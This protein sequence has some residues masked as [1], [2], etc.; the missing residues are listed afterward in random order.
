C[1][2]AM[3]IAPNCNKS[4]CTL[5]VAAAGGGIWKTDKALNASNWQY[6][7][8]SFASNAIGSLLIDPR[9]FSRNTVYAGTGEPNASAD[10]E[11]GVGVYKTTDGGQTWTLVPGS[12]IF[13][14]RSIGQMA[15][16]HAGT[17]TL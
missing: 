1:V 8:S 12:E 11:A 9:A 2:T 10:S 16:E 17:Q 3:A 7:S 14:N 5:Y 6:L 13:F 4:S 15:L